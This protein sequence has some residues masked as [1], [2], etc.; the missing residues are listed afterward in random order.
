STDAV[1]GLLEAQADPALAQADAAVPILADSR[2]LPDQLSFLGSWFEADDDV[3]RLL[4]GRQLTRAGRLALVEGEL[5]PRRAAKWVDRLAWTALLLCHSEE[6]EP[7]EAFFVSAKALAAG[8]P[9]AEIPLMA[10]VASLTVEVHRANRRE[11][12]RT[13]RK[14]PDRGA[15]RTTI[16]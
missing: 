2:D 13:P 16:N 5:L 10:H 4:A 7:W 3:E 8:R 1:F 6:E 12:R 14:K 15:G 11:R 9:I